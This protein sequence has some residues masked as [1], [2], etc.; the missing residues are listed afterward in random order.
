[1]ALLVGD[2]LR[3]MCSRVEEVGSKVEEQSVGIHKGQTLHSLQECEAVS[4]GGKV[5]FFLC[6]FLC[7]L[8]F[9]WLELPTAT[10]LPT[11][12][13]RA[14]HSDEPA[15][16]WELHLC[17][18]TSLQT[19]LVFA[20]SLLF[21]CSALQSTVGSVFIIFFSCWAFDLFLQLGVGCH[22]KSQIG[23]ESLAILVY[24]KLLRITIYK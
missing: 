1:M 21:A 16:H 23:I 22:P 12:Y 13:F 2:Q 6:V 10:P 5:P 8:E 9:D 4:S 20:C 15:L 7:L 14:C 11:H 3:T 17:S 24:F 18:S 19:L